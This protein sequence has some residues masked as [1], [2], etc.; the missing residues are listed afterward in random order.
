MQL[1]MVGVGRMGG[2]MAV[3]LMESGHE[4]VVYSA[5][6]ESREKFAKETGAT[7]ASSIVDFVAQL[8][9]PR[10]VWLMI[11]AGVVD[12]TLGELTRLLDKGDIIIDGGNSYYIDD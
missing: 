11:P 10:A 4:V 3:R 5:R 6:A 7:A 12:Q 9:P 1:G 2:N 8:S